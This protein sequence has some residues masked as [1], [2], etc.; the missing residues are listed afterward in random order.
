MAGIWLDALDDIA[1]TCQEHGRSDLLQAVRLKRAHLLDPT[2]TVLVVGEPNQGKSQLVNAIVNAPVCPVGDGRTTVLPTVLRHAEIA[3]ATVVQTPSTTPGTPPGAERSTVE[4]TPVPTEQIA[5]GVAGTTG[6]RPGAGPAYIEIGLPRALLG[7]GLVLVDMPGGESSAT[8]ASTPVAALTRADTVL[9]VSDSTR[10]L[11]VTELNRLLHLTRSHANVVVVQTKTDLVPDWRTVADRNR[12]HLADAGIPATLVPVSAALRL[13]AAATDDHALNAES[14]FPAL[15]ALLRRD[16]TGKPDALARAAVVLT[17][18]TVVEQL[19]APLRA[20]LTGAQSV[21]QSAPMTRLHAAQREVDELR[22]CSTR[23]QNTLTDEMA[24]LLSDIEHDLRDRTRHILNTVDEAFETADP[25][26]AWDSVAQWLER[27]L[28]EAAEA[29]RQWLVQRCEWV[30]RRVA[31]SFARY[32]HGTLPPWPLAVTSEHGQPLP[33]LERPN[34][35]RFTMGQK[36]FTGMKGSYGGLLMFGLA[37]TLA[38]L[39]MINPISLGA[40]ALFGGKSIRDEGRQLLR[41]RQATVK[42]AVQR[43]VDDFFVRVS[44]DSRDAA[45]RAQRLLR[46]HFAA[47]TEELQADIIESLRSAKQAADTDAVTRERRH[48]EIQQRMIRLAQLYEQA[49]QVAAARPAPLA[50]RT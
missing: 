10:D 34:V 1:R 5:A 33:E 14:G 39:P 31:D 8:G 49:Q 42:S 36:M 41:R 11:S 28:V 2:L 23:W 47:L 15:I 6:R 37:L 4:R 44:K 48:R 26:V 22:R 46:D 7:A 20:E 32:G 3:S 9:L 13:R 30:A 50:P 18:R 35:D 43:H 45:R 16:L 40:G 17:A 27:S 24:D 38:G 29:N 19:A 12:R 25:L 21:E